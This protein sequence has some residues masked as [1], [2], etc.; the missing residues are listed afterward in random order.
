MG[1]KDNFS[2]AV[3][4]LW[5]K[6]GQGESSIPQKGSQP[7]ELDKYLQQQNEDGGAVGGFGAGVEVNSSGIPLETPYY[8]NAVQN[9]A[10]PQ[11]QNP[12]PNP[13]M[14]QGMPS[15]QPQQPSQPAPEA[16]GGVNQNVRSV[17]GMNTPGAAG[18][19]ASQPQAS[20]NQNVQNNQQ[21]FG[22]N[23]QGGYVP[24]ASG[25]GYGGG[26]YVPPA[27]GG[28]GFNQGGYVPPA[29]GGGIAA[30]M[31]GE[32]EEMTVISK[33]TVIDGNVRS[34][35]N[36]Q[37]DGNIKGN[38]E[39]TRNIDMSGKIVGDIT[40][41]NA[42]MISAAMQGNVSLKGRMK[43]DRDTILIGDL[44]SQYADINGRIRGKLDIVGKA[45][46][47]R[48]AIVFGDINASTIAVTDGAIIQG[49]VNT[50]FLSKEDSRNVFPDAISLENKEGKA[51]A[52]APNTPN[53]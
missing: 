41:N 39:T 48:D 38:V 49:Y 31:A 18:A 52:A 51:A 44:T 26:G 8:P 16:A 3:K 25:G 1:I 33:N 22:Q 42:G 15:V 35:A 19:Q 28:P 5:K 6:D 23:N 2:Q 27:S 29:S 36:M 7:S 20:F 40:C 53:P 47:K 34:L 9:D 37:I 11:N 45:E 50:T 30:Q 32:T 13:G 24:P 21:N 12:N 17:Q 10:Q 4:E 14:T 46:L 43:M